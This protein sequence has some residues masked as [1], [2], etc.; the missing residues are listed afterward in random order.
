MRSSWKNR[1]GFLEEVASEMD[2]VDWRRRKA[3][4]ECH[5]PGIK[6]DTHKA[7]K[8]GKFRILQVFSFGSKVLSMTSHSL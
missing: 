4:A 3:K 2:T 8:K 7:N 6:K 5:S 1:R